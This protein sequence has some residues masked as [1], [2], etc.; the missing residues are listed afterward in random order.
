MLPRSRGQIYPDPSAC[1]ARSAAVTPPNCASS[2]IEIPLRSELAK[3]SLSF[4][5]FKLLRSAEKIGLR[6]WTIHRS[7]A[8]V[9]LANLPGVPR[10]RY[11]SRSGFR[12]KA[13]NNLTHNA[14]PAGVEGFSY[15]LSKSQRA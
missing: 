1:S 14:E 11:G 9:E 2:K 7:I 15:S 5:A 8:R 4:A 3:Y 10:S 12:G 6:R 13:K